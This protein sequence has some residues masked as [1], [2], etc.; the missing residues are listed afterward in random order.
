MTSC[1]SSSVNVAL[2]ITAPAIIPFMLFGG[3]FLNSGS[4]PVWLEWLQYLSWFNYAN[5]ALCINQW[6]NID[7]IDC[8][9]SPACPSN[10]TVVL[11]TLSYS[12]DNFNVDIGAL[13]A[14]LV[15]YRL[16]AY[17]ILLF[18]SYRHE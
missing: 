10:G 17:L 16:L 13:A 6:Q 9:G 3:F 15:G 14:L 11:E 5:E 2:A 4:V 12:V 18:K 8:G 7:H 1:S